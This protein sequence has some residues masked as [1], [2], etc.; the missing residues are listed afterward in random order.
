MESQQ[1]A[2]FCSRFTTSW[3]EI[4][5][6][7]FCGFRDFLNS[8]VCKI[9]VMKKVG[10]LYDLEESILRKFSVIYNSFE[11]KQGKT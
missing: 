4:S 10:L 9:G 8:L 6:P 1:N 3:Q 7:N 2:R 5:L 11:K